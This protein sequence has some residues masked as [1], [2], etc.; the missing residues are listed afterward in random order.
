MNRTPRLRSDVV[1]VE[2][3]YRGQQS[4]VVKDLESQKYYR[5][6]PVEVIVMRALDGVH[7]CGEVAAGLRAEG[8]GVSEAVVEGFAQKLNRMGL[9]ERSLAE[10]MIAQLAI[11][12][13][14][15]GT[16]APSRSSSGVK[17]RGCAGRWA[18]PTPPS[19]AGC[20]GSAFSSVGSS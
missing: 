5:F 2:Q 7:T 17:S 6:R 3:T 4:Y 11:K 8:L 1:I 15:S 18:I 16:G 12:T 14:G 13:A 9:I 20:R 10:R 19:T